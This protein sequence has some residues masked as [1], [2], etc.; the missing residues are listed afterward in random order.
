M[1]AKRLDFCT[2]S[3]LIFPRGYGLVTSLGAGLGR[4]RLDMSTAALEKRQQV[5]LELLDSE[6]SSS[7]AVALLV[8]TPQNRNPRSSS[9]PLL[10]P[11]ALSETLS[12]PLSLARARRMQ[13]RPCSKRR[14]SGMTWSRCPMSRA[15]V[16]HGTL[17]RLA[18]SRSCKRPA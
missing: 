11:R 2:G 9:R 5:H 18:S 12:R 4:A 3:S 10:R 8:P 13:R 17:P 14:S 1:T 6:R 15:A 16:M 7:T